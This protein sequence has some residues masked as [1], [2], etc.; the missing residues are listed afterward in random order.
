MKDEGQIAATAKITAIVQVFEGVSNHEEIIAA[1]RRRD[2]SY[3]KGVIQWYETFPK[4]PFLVKFL[5]KAL[6]SLASGAS[7]RS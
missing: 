7:L 1:L 2:V 3:I 4:N 5:K 6:Q